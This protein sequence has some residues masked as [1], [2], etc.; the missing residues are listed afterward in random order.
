MSVYPTLIE[1][2]FFFIVNTW[3]VLLKGIVRRE[4]RGGRS[5]SWVNS[6]PSASSSEWVV[7]K[8]M[9][10]IMA[11]EKAQNKTKQKT[12]LRG[13]WCRD[14]L[15]FPQWHFCVSVWFFLLNFRFAA[16]GSTQRRCWTHTQTCALFS[17]FFGQ[18]KNTGRHT[19]AHKHIR[20]WI[21][22]D[23]WRWVTSTF[24]IHKVLEVS[25]GLSSDGF[26]SLWIW[27][28]KNPSARLNFAK[29]KMRERLPS[30]RS[31]GRIFMVDLLFLNKC[32]FM[33]FPQFLPR[34]SLSYT[35]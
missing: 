14:R 28:L 24:N 4:P 18:K 23:G 35:L 27:R 1:A 6:Y 8:E 20:I 26:A 25:W 33:C 29:E 17:S 2:S 5:H 9:D 19:R 32:F 22:W 3:L 10:K 30:L 16:N 11:P 7:K 31:A 34:L 15:W 12:L 13:L 21:H